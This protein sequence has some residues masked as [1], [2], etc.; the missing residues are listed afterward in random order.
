MAITQESKG[1]QEDNSC[2]ETD[3]FY[4]SFQFAISMNLLKLRNS[5]GDIQKLLP[6]IKKPVNVLI[7]GILL[8]LAH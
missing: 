8:F 5:F 2:N 3:Y 4:L 6:M 7:Y 1:K